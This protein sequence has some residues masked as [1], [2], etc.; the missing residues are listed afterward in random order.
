M[1]VRLC[2]ER[3]TGNI[4]AMKKLRKDEMLRRGQARHLP[5]KQA[6]CGSP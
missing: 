6:I 3:T 5:D 2:R 1:Q 4:Y